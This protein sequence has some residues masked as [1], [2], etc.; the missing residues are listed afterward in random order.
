MVV[1]PAADA[2]CSLPGGQSAYLVLK[3]YALEKRERNI[4][5]DDWLICKKGHHTDRK[6]AMRME[7]IHTF[8]LKNGR[9]AGI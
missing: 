8:Y 6:A 9:R 5:H 1:R 7:S 3:A 4:I 2:A